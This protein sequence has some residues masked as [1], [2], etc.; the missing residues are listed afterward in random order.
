MRKRQKDVR[1]VQMSKSALKCKTR[2]CSSDSRGTYN[3]LHPR[4]R[5]IIRVSAIVKT[6]ALHCSR[7]HSRRGNSQPWRKVVYTATRQPWPRLYKTAT[8]CTFNLHTR[9][10]LLRQC[11]AQGRGLLS[12]ERST[13]Q[14]SR[15]PPKFT[16]R[17]RGRRRVPLWA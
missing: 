17:A 9:R 8:Y 6:Q 12:P 7:I 10:R 14:F 16:T 4:H 13:Q 11:K 15:Y 3:N 1:Q 2:E 5:H